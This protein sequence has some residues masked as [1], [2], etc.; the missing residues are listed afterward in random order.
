MNVENDFVEYSLPKKGVFH[1]DTNEYKLSVGWLQ[2][3]EESLIIGETD[4]LF[5]NKLIPSGHGEWVGDIVI[6]HEYIVCIGYRKSR[7]VRWVST[8][9]SLF[10]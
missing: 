2:K 10:K 6:Q 4:D 3:E 5:V 9:L 8:Q 7:F 1:V